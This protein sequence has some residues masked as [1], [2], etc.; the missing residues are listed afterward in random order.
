MAAQQDGRRRRQPL[1]LGD[2]QCG[3]A[4][5]AGAH[6]VDEGGGLR[7]RIDALAGPGGASSQPSAADRRKGEGG[8]SA[9]CCLVPRNRSR[10]IRQNHTPGQR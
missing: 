3:G 1:E 4:P 8:A 9:A 5:L 2:D 7:V 10:R 6:L